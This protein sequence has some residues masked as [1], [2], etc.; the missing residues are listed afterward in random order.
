M[1]HDFNRMRRA[2]LALQ[3]LAALLVACAQPAPEPTP[4]PASTARPTT[5]EVDPTKAPAPTPAPAPTA[6]PTSTPAPAGDCPATFDALDAVDRAMF[7]DLSSI[8]DTF[9][10]RRFMIWDDKY[11]FDDIPIVLARRDHAGDS[12]RYGF[13]FNWSTGILENV[14]PFKPLTYLDLGTVYCVS[15]LVNDQNLASVPYLLRQPLHI[16]LGSITITKPSGRQ[17]S[18]DSAF[19]LIYGDRS[20]EPRAAERAADPRAAERWTGYAVRQAFHR[21]QEVEGRLDQQF[22]LAS[23]ANGVQAEPLTKEQ[24]ALALLEQRVLVEALGTAGEDARPL[25]ELVA[26]RQLRL[27]RFPAATQAE[28]ALE[29]RDGTAEYVASRFAMAAGQLQAQPWREKLLAH[30]AGERAP[31]PNDSTAPIDVYMLQERPA[32]TGAALGFVMD[33]AA[34][35]WRPR[36]AAGKTPFDVLAAAIIVNEADRDA[37]VGQAK[38]RYNFAELETRAEVALAALK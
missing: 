13:L 17:T 26:V 15:P 37:L 12:P 22:Q 36:M 7:E 35:A 32:L 10:T 19:L 8:Q 2:V 3:A 1:N 9:V 27:A 25:S 21:W 16:D 33:A 31:E 29:Q 30:Y 34:I 11:R 28:Q 24:I 18:D 38:A 14:G 20:Q 6:A 4:V 5:V 23:V